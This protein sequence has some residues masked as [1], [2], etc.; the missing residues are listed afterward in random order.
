MKTFLY[1]NLQH[2][3]LAV[4]KNKLWMKNTI[5]VL[6]LPSLNTR[7]NDTFLLFGDGFHILSNAALGEGL[8]VISRARVGMRLWSLIKVV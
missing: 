7:N 3:H 5:S 8:G 2:S 6:N 4:K 1:K